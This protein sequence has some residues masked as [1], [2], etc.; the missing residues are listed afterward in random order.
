MR[1]DWPSDA[2]SLTGVPT[3][4]LDGKPRDRLPRPAA[5]KQPLSRVSTIPVVAENVQEPGRQHHVTIFPPFASLHANDHAFAVDR[6]WLQ[7][8]H[9][10]NTQ[11]CRVAHG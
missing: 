6:G 3:G 9:F 1:R 5:G 10:G 4:V 2:G 11:P 7:L 8:D